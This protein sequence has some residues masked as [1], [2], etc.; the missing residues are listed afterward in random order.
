MPNRSVSHPE[1]ATS[2]GGGSSVLVPGACPS[3]AD[4]NAPISSIG[5]VY[6]RDISRDGPLKRPPGIR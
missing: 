4:K 5:R 1:M 2:N 3:A 6:A